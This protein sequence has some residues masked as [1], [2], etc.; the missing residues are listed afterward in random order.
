MSD[1]ASAR[2]IRPRHRDWLFH[3]LTAEGPPRDLEAWQAA[4]RGPGSIPWHVDLDA[5]EERW[6]AMLASP[7]PPQRRTMALGECRAIARALREAKELDVEAS[8]LRADSAC[9][10]LDLNRLAPV[11]ARVL[12]LGE[13]DT[14]SLAWLWENWGTTMA[15]RHVELRPAPGRARPGQARV[16]M[17]FFSADWTPW[18]AVETMRAAWPALRIEA[19]PSYR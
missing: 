7:R 15:L 8:A 4:A 11:P 6:F 3:V 2:P 18:R 14:V 9:V 13:D 10:P 12:D 5:L 1:A 16:A 19:R 17:T